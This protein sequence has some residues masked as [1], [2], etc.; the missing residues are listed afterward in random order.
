MGKNLVGG[1]WKS[2]MD[3]LVWTVR[4][5]EDYSN[6]FVYEFLEVSVNPVFSSFSQGC[7]PLLGGRGPEKRGLDGKR[8]DFGVLFGQIWSKP[9]L[10]SP[11]ILK[12]EAP[13]PPLDFFA[14]K[15]F[16]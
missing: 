11:S 6:R 8:E 2:D 5:E 9:S 3:K 10:S 4:N 12:F 15:T 16:S 1:L 7:R 13:P 14:A